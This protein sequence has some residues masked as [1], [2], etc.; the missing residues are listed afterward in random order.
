MIRRLDRENI[1]K[2]FA[3]AGNARFFEDLGHMLFNRLF[4]Y[5]RQ[6]CDLEIR[7]AF[8]HKNSNF[9][10]FGRQLQLA[11]TSVHTILQGA[12]SFDHFLDNLLERLKC[13]RFFEQ[14]IRAGI[15]RFARVVKTVERR[16]QNTR[17]ANLLF[18]KLL[19]QLNPRHPWKTD[20]D[21]QEVM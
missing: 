17:C 9:V 6:L 12:R 11:Q 20:I 18:P 16:D 7:E 1:R 21:D 19:E 10:L 5:F 2:K 14:V 3:S 15:K 4:G 8:E 13:E